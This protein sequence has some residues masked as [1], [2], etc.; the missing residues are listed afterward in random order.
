[1]K[2]LR[3]AA[4]RGAALAMLTSAMM[5]LPAGSAAA[6]PVEPVCIMPPDDYCSLYV[7]YMIGTPAYQDCVQRATELHYGS[8]C[9]GPWSFSLAENRE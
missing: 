2:T 8:Y 3:K 9:G 4:L 5:S 7:G 1:M 6:G